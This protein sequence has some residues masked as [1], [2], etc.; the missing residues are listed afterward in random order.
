[1]LVPQAVGAA[2]QVFPGLDLIG[3]VG[4]GCS[5]VSLLARCSVANGAVLAATALAVV[6]GVGVV[7]LSVYPARFGW[8]CPGVGGIW[9]V[10]LEGFFDLVCL[11]PYG[12]GC[13]VG[14]GARGGDGLNLLLIRAGC[15]PL[16]PG[17]LLLLLVLVL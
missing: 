13:G 9:F 16:L 5:E 1:M 7:G 11:A 17:T 12:V 6:G 4:V 15:V 3:G 10:A 8:A 2:L 14:L